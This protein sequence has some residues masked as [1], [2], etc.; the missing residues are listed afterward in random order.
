[1]FSFSHLKSFINYLLKNKQ[2]TLITLVGFGISLMFVVV[3][4]LYVEKELSVDEF[5]KNKHRIYRLAN[6]CHSMFSPPMAAMLTETFPQFEAS[7]RIYS[8]EG[9]VDA[10]TDT[11]VQAKLLLVDST[12]FRMFSFHLAN[13]NPTEAL[14][15]TTSMVLGQKLAHKLFSESAPIGSTISCDG[16]DYVLNGIMDDFP[17]NTIFAEYDGV[18]NFTSLERLWE[19]EEILSSFDNNSFG[20]FVMARDNSDMTQLAE[21]T[22]KLFHDEDLWLYTMGYAKTVVYEPLPDVYFS[23]NGSYTI[24]TGNMQTILILMAVAILVLVLSIINYINLTIAQSGFR[25]KAIAIRKLSGSTRLNLVG[26]MVF[27]SVIL[28][29]ASLGI[30]LLFALFAEPLFNKILEGNID[31]AKQFSGLHW[32]VSIGSIVIIGFVSGILPA[33]H[34]TSINPIDIVKGSLAFKTKTRYSKVLI[35]FQ[36][37]IV[38]ALLGGT[39]AIH[40]QFSFMKNY[41]MG[42]RQS[43]MLILD[44]RLNENQRQTFRAEARRIP[45]VIDVAY[46]AGTPLDGGNNMSFSHNGK[47]VGFQIFEVDSAFLEMMQ[48]KIM[49]TGAAFE[50]NGVYINRAAVA[51]MELDSLP[52]QCPFYD[53]QLTVLGVVQDFSYRDLYTPIGPTIIKYRNNNSPWQIAIGLQPEITSATITQLEELYDKISDGL[54]FEYTSMGETIEQWMAKERRTSG[55][56]FYF[57]ILSVVISIMGIYAMSIYYIQQK[58]KEIA[59]RKI[60]GAKIPEVVR[61]LGSIY[62]KIT[63]VAFVIIT[64]VTIYVVNIWMQQFPYRANLPWFAFLLAGIL[65]LGVSLLTVVGQ[66][67]R[68]AHQNPVYSLRYE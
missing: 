23:K 50:K 22:L 35:G 17:D 43:N 21:R 58:R 42:F 45:G 54:P 20:I 13:G 25:S 3:L 27:E 36:I 9:I 12:F 41:D 38:I 67:W 57:S 30:G 6:D 29:T 26:Q 48:F 52:L 32:L 59:I 18:V 44:N 24:K 8:Y 14:R 53:K 47:S 15:S 63:L 60:N 16:V 33:L 49:P 1:M 64:P 62:L 56:M 5:H 4:S 10:G 55:I 61:L 40:N 2:Y 65:T 39:I 46:V 68:A 7:T 34:I 11:K 51:T 31:I 37:A 28:C 19:N 66:L